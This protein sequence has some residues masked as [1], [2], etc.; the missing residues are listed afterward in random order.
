MNWLI[1][2]LLMVITNENRP[3]IM[4]VFNQPDLMPVQIEAWARWVKMCKELDPA[5]P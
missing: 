2:L 3:I 1:L 5:R 4:N